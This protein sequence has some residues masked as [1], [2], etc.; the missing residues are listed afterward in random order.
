MLGKKAIIELGLKLGAPYQYTW[1]CYKGERLPCGDCDSC[2]LWAAGFA[3][4]GAVDPA[5]AYWAD[6]NTPS[7]EDFLN[8]L[9]TTE[10][11]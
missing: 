1:S 2:K 8:T 3:E 7:A 4:L 11:E 5:L 10:M 9:T 6:P